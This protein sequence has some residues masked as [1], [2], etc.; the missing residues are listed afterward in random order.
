M[1]ANIV[2]RECKLRREED[3]QYAIVMRGSML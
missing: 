1:G 2:E 3:Q